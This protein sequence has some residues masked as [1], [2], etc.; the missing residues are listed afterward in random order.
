ME[1]YNRAVANTLNRT[2]VMSIPIINLVHAM[3][4][5]CI[6]AVK[7]TKREKITKKIP[8]P[9]IGPVLLTLNMLATNFELRAIN[10]PVIPELIAFISKTFFNTIIFE[11]VSTKLS[12]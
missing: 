5:R 10:K 9:I 12:S 4:W 7:R 3:S 1:E 2:Q 6:K 11:F 8:T